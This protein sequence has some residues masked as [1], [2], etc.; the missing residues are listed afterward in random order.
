[1]TGLGAKWEMKLRPRGSLRL[2][3]PQDLLVDRSIPAAFEPDG[4]PVRDTL[5]LLGADGVSQQPVPD[6]PHNRKH[7]RVNDEEVIW[8][9]S[10]NG[11]YG[12]FLLESTSRLWP[13]LSDEKLEGLPAVFAGNL[14][15]PGLVDPGDHPFMAEW[16]DAFGV[17]IVEVAD[18]PVR[19]KRMHVPEPALRVGAWMSTELRDIH[20]RARR[21]LGKLPT[22][23]PG[24]VVWLSRSNLERNRRVAHDECLLEWLLRDYIQIVHPQTLTLAG[25]VAE[26]E[27]SR[28]IVGIV[29]S[30]FYTLLLAE[31]V[32]HFVCLCSAA[33]AAASPYAPLAE[34]VNAN[35]NLVF[36]LGQ[37]PE[38]NLA[39]KTNPRYH[40]RL[41]I[42]RI[43]RSLSETV[44][45]ELANDPWI[46]TLAHVEH[47]R[48]N[49]GYARKPANLEFAVAKVL[50][51][52]LS[53]GAR[54]NL[55]RHFEARHLDS[56]A[57][58]QYAVVAD[59]R[60]HWAPKA[61]REARRMARSGA[62][63][64]AS[65]MVKGLLSN[66]DR[67]FREAI[68]LGPASSN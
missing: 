62:A 54:M 49:D 16:L 32:P 22:V 28:A 48:S 9:G 41:Q 44:L 55:A 64:T 45:P 57:L 38:G 13:L 19:F 50:L 23:A 46:A 30:A 33:W 8:A 17:R 1:M 51:E 5:R 56:L 6:I 12:H 29:G 10:L 35:A 14:F 25:Q 63:D 40:H 66:F 60:G 15:S 47:L 39:S 65:P 20:L 61:L 7:P 67:A 4:R 37:A 59:L 3:D 34:L 21:G 53:D 2:S 11:H 31:A 52:P 43:L 68:A 58:E 36:A 27:A 18:E 24:K 26:V 42:P